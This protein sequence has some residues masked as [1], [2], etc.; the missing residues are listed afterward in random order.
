MQK[1]QSIYSILYIPIPLKV[2]KNMFILLFK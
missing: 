2:G 1:G